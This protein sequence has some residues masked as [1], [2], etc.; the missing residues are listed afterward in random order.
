MN[1]LV[2]TA[3]PVASAASTLMMRLLNISTRET[4]ETAASPT[5]E[6]IIVSAIPTVMAR[7]CS[8]I[9]GIISF[10][11]SLLENIMMLPPPAH[12]L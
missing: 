4:P 11:R 3:P 8:R 10:F 7:V 12:I 1:W 9:S 6:I 2:T 5:E